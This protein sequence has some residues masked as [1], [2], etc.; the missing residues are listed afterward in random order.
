MTH[1]VHIGIDPGMSG[2]IAALADGTPELF[3]MPLMRRRV[4]GEQVNA[5]ELATIL[6]GIRL[7]HQG[8]SFLVAV[9]EVASRP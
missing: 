6:R 9:E 5:A 8:A 4:K 2:A 7:R 1:H 3:D